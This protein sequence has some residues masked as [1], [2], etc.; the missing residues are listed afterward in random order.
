VREVATRSY[1]FNRK[2]SLNRARVV[3][4]LLKSYGVHA[5]FTVHSTGK[6]ESNQ[7]SAKRADIFVNYDNLLIPVD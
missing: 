6:P 7:A 3:A 1:S 5:T 4:A 2:L